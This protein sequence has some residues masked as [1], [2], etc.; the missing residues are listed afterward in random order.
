MNYQDYFDCALQ[1]KEKADVLD[2]ILKENSKNKRYS[3][4]QELAESERSSRLIYEM[5][6]E[7]LKTMAVLEKRGREIMESENNAN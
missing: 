5:K 6:L 7:C 4:V 1:Y 3:T 2:R